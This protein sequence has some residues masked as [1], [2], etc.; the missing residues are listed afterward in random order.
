MIY[1]KNKAELIEFFTEDGL[2][3]H[4]FLMSKNNRKAILFIHGMGGNF[5]RN[6]AIK[7]SRIFLNGGFDLFSTN[8]RGHDEVSKFLIKRRKKLKSVIIGASFEKFEDSV[9]D[10][11]SAINILNSMKYRQIILV[12]HST[13]CQK[14]IYYIYKTRDI[15]IKATILLA[16]ADDYNLQKE[17]FGRLFRSLNKKAK[18]LIKKR[19]G[20]KLL[21]DMLKERD[22]L[23]SAQRFNSVTDLNR[24]ESRLFN[25]EGKLRE[26]KKIKIPILVIWGEKEQHAI[27]P[28]KKYVE[29]LK[30]NTSSKKF[31]SLIIKNAD[32][33]FRSYENQVAHNMVNWIKGTIKK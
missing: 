26:F 29:I 11:K 27:L 12:G 4:G 8:T 1:Q 30:N 5:Y 32:H 28:I 16:P 20:N 24:V 31:G 7:M 22:V 6:I 14:A 13:G 10:I 15:R 3:L 25:Y 21:F 18:I 2:Q 19:K 23:W 9:Y 17:W 33:G